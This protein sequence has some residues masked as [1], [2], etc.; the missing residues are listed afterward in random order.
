MPHGL[1]CA[2]THIT[3]WSQHLMRQYYGAHDVIAVQP[4]RF[5]FNVNTAVNV[6]AWPSSSK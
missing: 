4:V 2:F 1:V 6:F 3:W 5:G